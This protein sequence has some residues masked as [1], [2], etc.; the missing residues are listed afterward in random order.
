MLELMSDMPRADI[1]FE[2]A[3]DAALKQIEANRITRESIFWNYLSAKRLGMDYDVRR[4]NYEALQKMSIDDLQAFFDEHIKGN[5]YNYLVIGNKDLMQLE[6]LEK[7][8]P[9]ETLSLETLF[10]Y[11]PDEEIELSMNKK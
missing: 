1:Q 6:V 11:G 10:G 4:E 7:L 5:S 9:V 3:R 2:S 8:G